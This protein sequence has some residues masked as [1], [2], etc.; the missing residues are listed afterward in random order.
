MKSNSFST[1]DG[2]GLKIAVVAARFNQELTDAM[3]ADCQAAL[4]S[5]HVADNDTTVLRVPGSFELPVAAATL[6]T[7][8]TYDA[9][10]CLGV[11]IKGDTKHDH[12]IADAVANGLTNIAIQHHIPVI[13]GVLTTENKVQAETRALGGQKKGWEAGMSA[14]ET[15]HALNHIKLNTLL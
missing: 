4:R 3:L 12:Y 1:L 8:S 13:F 2:A 15:I 11:I 9:I 10:I 5:A 14:I 6:A 7:Q